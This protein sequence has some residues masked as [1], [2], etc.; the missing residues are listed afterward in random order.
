[1]QAGALSLVVD[2]RTVLMVAVTVE[3]FP[4]LTYLA[5]APQVWRQIFQCTCNQT[6]APVDNMWGAGDQPS[7]HADQLSAPL[8][9]RSA[10][11]SDRGGSGPRF[12]LPI[13]DPEWL[14]VAFLVFQAL[15]YKANTIQELGDFA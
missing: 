11:K 12:L 7:V 14:T 3:K 6:F 8:M 9:P 5:Q 10:A 1:M 15:R 4:P 13:E 2:G